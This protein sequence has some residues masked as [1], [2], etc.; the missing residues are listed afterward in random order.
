MTEKRL[1][2]FHRE[3]CEDLDRTMKF[4]LQHSHDT[5]YGGFLNCL[6]PTGEVFDETK[7]IWFQGR[8]VWTYCKLYNEEPSYRRTDV[9]NAA[10]SGAEFLMKYA[11]LPNSQKCY[12]VVAR[13]GKPIKIQRSIFSECFYTL[14]MSEIARA[15]KE[16]K[17]KNE[18][19]L[20]MDKIV[21]WVKDDWTE[22]RLGQPAL[23]GQV[24]TNSLAVPMMVL[25][26]IDQMEIVYPELSPK[27]E[28]IANLC[29]KQTLSHV[30]RQGTVIL[31]NVT[32]DGR[33][34]PGSAGRVMLPGHSIEAGWFLLQY[35]VKK[36][37]PDLKVTAI[38]K[39]VKNPF[40]YG[41]DKDYGGLFYYLD[42][43]GH[44]PVQLE[45]NM[46]LWW[47][48]N[49]T[50]IA[51]LMAYKETKDPSMLDHFATVF[52]YCYTKHVDRENG[53][54]TG[55]LNRDGT[56][57]KNYKGGPWKGCFHLPRAL[58]MCKSM[59]E[60]LLKE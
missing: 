49:E 24:P 14:A 25:C 11:K 41:W 18:A 35:A 54:W 30:Q 39:F 44:S 8:Q 56:P 3:I 9:L 33:E 22:V 47:A 4:W 59:L 12:L 34:L 31:E 50:L 40:N 28:E 57:S 7:Y 20:M 19:I 36:N 51:F 38:E 32:P 23:E 43:D 6:G 21:Y 16:Q 15:T 48:H 55:Y 60:E 52:E 42:V 45:W 5:K 27:Y 26:L 2:E 13:D 53:D 1:K 10:I 37:L 17:Y 46:K 29:L 58:L